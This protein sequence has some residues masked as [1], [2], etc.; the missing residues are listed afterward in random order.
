MFV[1]K[2]SISI[3]ALVF[4]LGLGLYFLSPFSRSGETSTENNELES[5]VSQTPVEEVKNNSEGT[6]IPSEATAKIEAPTAPTA[7]IQKIFAN[8]LRS[9]GQCLE[10]Q[11]SVPGDELEPSL[12]TLVDSV[13]G[14][15]GESV[16]STEDWMQVDLE[17]QEG[18]KRRIRVEMDFDN[19]TQIQRKLKYVVV[20]ANGETRPISVPEEQAV[21]P[22]DSLIASLEVGNKIITREKFER[23]Y[24]QNGEEIV[25]R[26]QNGFIS[27]L[28]VN[29]GTKSF[30]CKGVNSETSACQCL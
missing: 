20:D 24:F 22:S 1:N 8:T 30:K 28:E 13:R 29:K 6:E 21:E 12:R 19:E 18:E 17:T 2:S 11:N 9:L 23:V 5:E 16:I 26:Q 3:F 15:W 10:T 14:E 4:F 27:E 7:N 25:A